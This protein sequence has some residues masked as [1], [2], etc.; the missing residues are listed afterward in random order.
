MATHIFILRST[1]VTQ[2]KVSYGD[3]LY[4]WAEFFTCNPECVYVYVLQESIAVNHGRKVYPYSESVT[5]RN[6]IRSSRTYF[7]ASVK[8]LNF[9]LIHS[10][11]HIFTEN[12]PEL[13]ISILHLLRILV[14]L[15]MAAPLPELRR[16]IHKFFEDFHFA[17]HTAAQTAPA[18]G[19]A[20]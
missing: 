5:R 10:E 14:F 13:S 16:Q 2:R 7:A 19:T 4:R 6:Y 1:R 11:S 8:F 12:V 20:L 15:S 17:T 3:Q 18:A 9:S